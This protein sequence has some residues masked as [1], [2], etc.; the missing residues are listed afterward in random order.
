MDTVTP[1]LERYFLYLWLGGFAWVV[2]GCSFNAW[3]RRRRGLPVFRP[4]FATTLFEEQWCSGGRGLFLAR[5][6][7]WVAVLSDRLVT[8]LH[9]PFNLPFPLRWLAWAGL[10]TRI[11]IQDIVALEEANGLLG[12]SLE[13]S[14]R[15]PSGMENLELALPKRDKMLRVLRELRRQPRAVEP[16]A[17]ADGGQR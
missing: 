2:V 7:V 9:F 13:I 10:V 5:N 16:A 1:W 14:Y 12:P 8:G 3:R 11:A 17:A 4:R 15:T 6:C